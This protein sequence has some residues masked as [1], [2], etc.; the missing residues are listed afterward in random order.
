MPKVH[1]REGD[2]VVILSGKDRDKR[3]K[4]LEVLPADGKVVVE[5]INMVKRHQRP[6]RADRQGGILEK[7]GAI[8][9]AKVMLICPRC[10][11]PSRTGQKILKS[12]E[13]VRYC[14]KCGEIN[15]K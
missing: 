9:T 5:G 6:T 8:S 4:I 12:G 15:E 7:E 1:V 11:K 14:K 10:G 2:R 3:G 13:K